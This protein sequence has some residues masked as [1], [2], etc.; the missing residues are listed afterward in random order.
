VNVVS[1]FSGVGGLDLGLHQAGWHHTLLCERD[2]YRRAV[3]AAR[4][5][6]VPILDDVRAVAHQDGDGRRGHL[7]AVGDD[8]RVD[9]E[10]SERD[11]WARPDLLC[12]GFPCQDLSVAG[13]RAGLAGERSGL[14]FEFARI[15]ESVRPRWLLIENVPGLLT[16]N[17]G[18]DF[19]EL[20]GTL[21]EVGYGV[22]WRVLDSRH[23]G[24][25]QRRRRVFILC[26]DVGGRAGAEHAGQVLAV[27]QGCQR[28]PQAG[29]EAGPGT[30]IGASDGVAHTLRSEG[31]DAS[32]DGTGRGAPLV[33]SAP[34]TSKWAKGS[35]GPAGDEAQNLVITL[36]APNGRGYRIDAEAAAGGHLQPL[37]GTGVRRLTPRE[38]E[39]LQGFPDDWTLIPWMGKPAPDSRRYAALGDAVTVPVA[40]WLGER[41]MAHTI[42]EA[43][44]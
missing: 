31:A 33:V 36:Q 4:F 29:G 13:R 17:G 27:G 5:P 23:F 11:P 26:S 19:G 43:A 15:A 22:A 40:R 8:E 1:T 16:S 20:L 37:P 38:C 3:L 28:H 7:A 30:A 9:G 34:V 6:G 12:G 10:P 42:M 41:L 35:G 14:F 25:P 2:E 18:R 32:E 21:A 44:A 24:V 39:R